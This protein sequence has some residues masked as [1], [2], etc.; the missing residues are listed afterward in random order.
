MPPD[1]GSGIQDRDS[2]GLRDRGFVGGGSGGLVQ[3][4][5]I[6]EALRAD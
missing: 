4:K 2:A 1:T 5:E 3:T 6:L